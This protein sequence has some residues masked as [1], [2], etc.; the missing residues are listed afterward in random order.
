VLA[1]SIGSQF[2]SELASSI[3]LSGS[4]QSLSLLSLLAPF[5]GM[6]ETL[7]LFSLDV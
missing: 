3:I 1:F 2:S 6:D 4:K 7:H 5:L